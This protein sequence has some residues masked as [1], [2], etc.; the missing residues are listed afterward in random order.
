MKSRFTGIHVIKYENRYYPYGYTMDLFPEGGLTEDTIKTLQPTGN[1][2]MLTPTQVEWILRQT[3]DRYDNEGK[4]FAKTQWFKYGFSIMFPVITLDSK[5]ITNYS[6]IPMYLTDVD[7][8]IS[9]DKS[10]WDT[11][12]TSV[13]MDFLSYFKDMPYDSDWIAYD[14]YGMDFD[15]MLRYNKTS[16]IKSYAQ[17]DKGYQERVREMNE[18]Q[19]KFVKEKHEEIIRQSNEKPELSYPFAYDK[20]LPHLVIP[21]NAPLPNFK[22]VLELMREIQQTY[23]LCMDLPGLKEY[24]RMLFVESGQY[25]YK[26]KKLFNL[27]EINANKRIFTEDHPH[28]RF[29]QYIEENPYKYK[30]GNNISLTK[31]ARE[32]LLEKMK[33]KFGA[34]SDQYRVAV[35]YHEYL[36]IINGPLKI[37]KPI[38]SAAE[39]HDI[40]DLRYEYDTENGV[41]RFFCG[42][43]LVKTNRVTT[44][45][46][47]IQGQTKVIK[48]YIRGSRKGRKIL[49][50]D[51]KAQE[52]MILIFGVL[53][54]DR[55]KK[56]VLNNKDP[57]KSFA[58]CAGLCDED[59]FTQELKDLIKV[60]VLSVMNGKSERNIK[61]ELAGNEHVADVIL[62]LITQD[63]GYKRIEAIARE[64]QRKCSKSRSYNVVR[65]GLF[66]TEKSEFDAE[67]TGSAFTQSINANFQMTAS[68]ILCYGLNCMIID[69]GTEE[70]KYGLSIDQLTPQVTIYDEVI[71]EYDEE[72]EEQAI[73]LVNFYICPQVEGWLEMSG[74]IT[75]GDHYVYKD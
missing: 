65:R 17:D 73:E 63:P 41:I 71:F 24:R 29:L 4:L 64:E 1:T 45:R 7:A 69:L 26:F 34:D 70:N 66:G 42:M 27:V 59:T 56:L 15:P 33:E 44:N 23:G 57:Y 43:E 10:E 55:L 48:S 54:N 14:L 37:G 18:E 61:L 74:T 16:K 32:L 3:L 21:K 25:E 39:G 36:N 20:D 46:P 53:Q 22:L 72:V 52:V 6:D 5:H 9:P 62:E 38:L 58:I 68:E 67:Q 13:T 28:F 40:K 2:D 75:T 30:K 35:D 8:I 60:P 31:P 11:Y 19:A 47:N 51:I 49:S 50:I 12:L